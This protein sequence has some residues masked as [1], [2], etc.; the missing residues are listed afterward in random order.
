[1]TGSVQS[2]VVFLKYCNTRK[3][4][5]KGVKVKRKEA[6]HATPAEL[7]LLLTQYK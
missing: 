3:H 1:M 7:V 5:D 6:Q 2:R 4:C